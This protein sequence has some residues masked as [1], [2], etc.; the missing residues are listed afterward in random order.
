MG[1]TQVSTDG[2]KN[3]AITKVKIPANQIEASEIAANAVTSAKIADSAVSEAKLGSSVVSTTK[4]ADSAVTAGKLASGVQTTINNNA[5]NRVITGSS[6]ANTLNA[7]S[8]MI[9]DSSGNVCVGGNPEG[10]EFQV[11]DASGAA[12]IRAKDGANNKIVDLIANST[13]GLL[14]TVGAYPLVL[15]TN[16]TERMRIDSSGNVGIAVTNPSTKLQVQQDWVANYGS[17]AVEGSN[18]A[19]VGIGLRSSGTY[20]A[21]LIYRDGSSGDSLELATQGTGRPILL[22]PNNTEEVRIDS[23]GLKF[24]GDTAA[25]NALDDYEEGTW[26]PGLAFG[27]NSSATGLSY[28]N[29]SG[30][31]TKIGNLVYIKAHF[32]ISNA[33][34]STGHARI[35][36]LP[37]QSAGSPNAF[38][39][40]A[41]RG[42]VNL[43]SGAVGMAVYL[44]TNSSPYLY[45]YKFNG[46]QNFGVTQGAFS[47]NSEID[48]N[49]VYKAT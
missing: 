10:F 28:G 5:D 42:T 3:D 41:D 26:T 37:F 6:S 25:A 8:S 19:L 7:E 23:D 44:D 31:Y 22:K 35:T 39:P 20:R 48:V 18:N 47:T 4:I 13:G 1:L 40:I 34:S 38:V 21:A 17:I 24:N 14:R 12:V 33:G 11:T 27:S 9:I 29:R 36:G 15:N 32:L 30:V 43:G 45:G 16:Q 49:F 2:V 46:S